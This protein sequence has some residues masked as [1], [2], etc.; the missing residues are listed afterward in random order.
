MALL[1]LSVG[2]DVAVVGFVKAVDAGRVA[3]DVGIEGVSNS[4]AAMRR[5]W[6]VY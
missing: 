6:V 3:K 5:A 4:V 1:M 2:V